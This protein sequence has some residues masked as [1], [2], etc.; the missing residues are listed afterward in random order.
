MDDHR[1]RNLGL[2][3]GGGALIIA[4]GVAAIGGPGKSPDARPAAPATATATPSAGAA[5]PIPGGP[6]VET[7]LAD[8]PPP[9]SIPRNPEHPAANAEAASNPDLEF[10]VRFDDRHPMSRAQALFLQGKTADAEALARETLARRAELSGLCFEH[11]TLGAE[12]VL[13]H[14]APVPHSQQRRTSARWVRKLKA[15]PGVQYADANVVVAPESG[16]R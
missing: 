8:G 13:S 3:G 12:L 15:I 1:V 2:I 4:L 5:A 9:V 6:T 7:A 10:I 14:C 11:F 16:K